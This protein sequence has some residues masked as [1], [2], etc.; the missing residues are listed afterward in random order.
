M[1]RPKISCAGVAFVI[2]LTVVLR[3]QAQLFKICVTVSWFGVLSKLFVLSIF[4]KVWWIRS[5]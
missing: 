3:A 2:V 5:T 1:S 4:P